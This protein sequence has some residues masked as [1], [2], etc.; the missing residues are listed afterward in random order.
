MRS[1][2]RRKSRSK[3]GVEGRVVSTW[4]VLFQAG[5]G[6]YKREDIRDGRV[7]PDDGMVLTDFPKEQDEDSDKGSDKGSRSNARGNAA[8]NSMG[9][10]RSS[11][12]GNAGSNAMSSTRG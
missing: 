2:N 9:H 7:N 12:P 4:G 5:I 1:R 11:S 10:A 3:A 6:S 8:G